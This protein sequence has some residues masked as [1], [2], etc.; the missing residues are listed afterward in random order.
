MDHPMIME[1]DLF[2]AL[3]RIRTWA[4]LLLFHVVGLVVVHGCNGLQIYPSGR[5]PGSKVR[6]LGPVS[7]LAPELQAS[8][9]GFLPEILKSGKNSLKN[10]GVLPILVAG[11]NSNLAPF[12]RSQGPQYPEDPI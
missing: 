12:G 11:K 3:R 2:K 9:A 4:E 8:Q 7:T 1:P 5:S 10:L 6:I